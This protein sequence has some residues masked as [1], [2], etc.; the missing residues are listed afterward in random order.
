VA[1]FDLILIGVGVTLEPIPITGFILVLSAERGALKGASFI[2]GW[3]VSL[4]VI[5]AGVVLVTGGKPPKPATAPSTTVLA[6]KVFLGVALIFLAFRRHSRVGTKPH[7]APTWM[8]KVDHMSVWAAAP[9]GLL[10]QPWVL[11]AAGAAAVVQLHVSSVES[12]ILLAVFCLV[13]TS[14][15]LAM[16][17][18]AVFSPD[19]AKRRLDG[20]RY[21]I[22]THRDQVIVFIALIVGLWLVGDD[23]YLIAS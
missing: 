20:L 6:I 19:E 10:L 3:L 16:E 17:L 7:K 13:C 14:S 1:V 8:A 5:V 12:F 9:F 21:W 11:V 2:L 18:Y 15:Y 23:L 4:V 22:E